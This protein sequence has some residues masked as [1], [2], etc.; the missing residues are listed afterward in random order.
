[1][2]R[3]YLCIVIAAVGWLILAASNPVLAK[4]DNAQEKHQPSGHQS[5]AAPSP[6]ARAKDAQIGACLGAEQGNLSCEAIAAKAAYDQA[7]DADRQTWVGI[8]GTIAVVASLI[9]SALAT[10]AAFG[11]VTK[12]EET[13]TETKKMNAAIVRPIVA[14][15]SASVAFDLGTNKPMIMLTTRNA[16]DRTARDWEWKP[17]LK[18]RVGAVERKSQSFPWGRRGIAGIDLPPGDKRSQNPRTIP[19]ELSQAEQVA[20]TEL[21]IDNGLHISLKVFALCFDVFGNQVDDEF[22]FSTTAFNL[23]GALAQGD[24]GEPVFTLQPGPP[25]AQIEGQEDVVP[26]GLPT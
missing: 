7:R 10:R 15:E 16:S 26:V 9:F 5:D 22:H 8:A 20:I 24:G 21:E 6:S 23:F 12:A 18:Y 19:F 13:L 25:G 14:I 2:P 17:L 11:A 3:G 4:P 1:M